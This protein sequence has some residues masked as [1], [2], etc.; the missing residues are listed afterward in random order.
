MIADSIP[1]KED[2]LRAADHFAVTN[3][4]RAPRA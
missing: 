2:L 1:W 4:A 3:L